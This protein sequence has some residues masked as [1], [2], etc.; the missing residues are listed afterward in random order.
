MILPS[1]RLTELGELKTYAGYDG[2]HDDG[3]V[4]LCSG[5]VSRLLFDV[6]CCF[7]KPQDLRREDDLELI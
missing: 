3:C 2:A 7:A 1:L 5:E 6:N 4:I